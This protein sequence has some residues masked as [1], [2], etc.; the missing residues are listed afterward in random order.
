MPPAL[1]FLDV[2]TNRLKKTYKDWDGPVAILRRGPSGFGVVWM[3][4]AAAE[5]TGYDLG[6]L[7]GTDGSALVGPSTDPDTVARIYRALDTS[8]PY[9]GRVLHYRKDGRP[10]WDELTLVP[11]LGRT[12]RA[13]RYVALLRDATG[14]QL[15]RVFAQA[16]PGLEAAA[17]DGLSGAEAVDRF[18]DHVRPAVPELDVTVTTAA[19]ADD[20]PHVS[21]EIPGAGSDRPRWVEVRAGR[22]LSETEGEFFCRVARAAH[23]V[24]SQVEWR[25]VLEHTRAHLARALHRLRAPLVAIDPASGDLLLVNPAAARLLDL[26]DDSVTA[27]TR[28]FN[29]QPSQFA[30]AVEGCTTTGGHQ[31]ICAVRNRS[32]SYALR[33]L[34]LDLSLVRP[35]KS[36]VLL[37]FIQD[38]SA[39]PWRQ[40][41][42]REYRDEIQFLK[43][44]IPDGMARFDFNPRLSVDWTD[45]EVIHTAVRFG[46]AMDHNR[47]FP[48][49]YGESRVAVTGSSLG[50]LFER[51]PALA[52]AFVDA[53]RSPEEPVHAEVEVEGADGV[54]RSLETTVLARTDPNDRSR[55]A[56]VWF[57]QR[58]LTDQRQTE[59]DLF[60]VGHA[61]QERLAHDLH[62]GLGQH[63]HGLQTLLGG[64]RMGVGRELG[65]DHRLFNDV[66]DVTARAQGIVDMMRT[67][68][69]SF[70]PFDEDG[71]QTLAGALAFIPLSFECMDRGSV[72]VRVT[73]D[74]PEPSREISEHLYA[75]AAEAVTNA[76]RHGNASEVSIEVDLVKC[77]VHDTCVRLRVVDDGAGF[78][79]D[80]TAP[81]IGTKSLHSRAKSLHGAASV[82]SVPGTGTTVTLTVPLHTPRAAPE[83][84]PLHDRPVHA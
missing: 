42:L 66:A 40:A 14:D 4:E 10:F 18:L 54:V 35:F 19:P 58:D 72:R 7:T 59:R 65:R 76:H 50:D 33:T 21:F 84:A 79:P 82:Q 70:S 32:N 43:R 31:L 57:Y 20:S 55:V 48:R 83:L 44:A 56:S 13:V 3:N 46:I 75:V 23:L 61:E 81:G 15:D 51:A 9:R 39:Q 53:C 41:E 5:I 29:L 2:T 52:P 78:D 16:V 62:D 8:T 80:Q 47:E 73:P 1:P 68:S 60:R 28:A 30:E 38:V 12:G 77:S 36:D 6:D 64:L 22:A 69:R 27:A 63:V 45:A 11:V 49:L 74:L 26:E 17:R 67:I 24:Y 34:Q 25:G 71:A 37:G